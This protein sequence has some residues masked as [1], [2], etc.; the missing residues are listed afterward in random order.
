MRPRLLQP[1]TP[2]DRFAHPS[3]A[4]GSLTFSI[5][6]PSKAC[7]FRQFAQRALAE[8]DVSSHVVDV[9]ATVLGPGLQAAE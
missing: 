5:E 7:L 9:E 8:L 3:R 6:V 1:W 2:T 4:P